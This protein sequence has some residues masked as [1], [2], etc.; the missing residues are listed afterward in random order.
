MTPTEP[1]FRSVSDTAIWAAIY[2]ARETDRPHALFRDPLAR[3]L[4]GERGD[5][6][7]AAMRSQDRNEWAWVIRTYLFDRFIAEQVAQ[8]ADMVVN[9]AAGL[10]ARPYRMALPATL[11]WIE[12]DL[13]ALLDEKEEILAGEKPACAL[14]RVRLD[15][16]DAAGRRD[17]FRRLAERSKTALIVTEGLL[18]YFTEAGVGALAEDLAQPESFR[19]WA[20][21]VVS[22]GLLRM[23][24]RQVG[25]ALDSAGA[26]FHF[27]PAEGP[28]F[29]RRHGWRPAAVQS[30]LKAAA[31][32]KRVP[33]WMRL[34]ARLP[35][36]SG[37][38]GSRIWSGV[39][40][41]EKS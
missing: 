10:D 7:A 38:Q 30:T 14:E 4:A 19:Y 21:D 40:L 5:R 33:L 18:I 1:T 39:C 25:P 15:L 22:P 16:A 13:P 20:A 23:L 35:E 29:F 8:G 3:R 12:V 27:A 24:S 32:E 41:L 31:R 6:I 2:R 28:A 34:V 9:L 17:L 37:P 36:P 11:H 26:P